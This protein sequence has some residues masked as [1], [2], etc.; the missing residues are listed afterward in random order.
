[1]IFDCPD[2]R[3]QQPGKR[4]ER[5]AKPPNAQ[6]NSGDTGPMRHFKRTEG[7]LQL[8][9]L[10]RFGRDGKI[11]AEDFKCFDD[12]GGTTRFMGGDDGYMN[13]YFDC[14][15][16]T[17]NLSFAGLFKDN[18][19]KRRVYPMRI[20]PNMNEEELAQ[21]WVWA[22]RLIKNKQFVRSWVKYVRELQFETDFKPFQVPKSYGF[23]DDIAENTAEP[24]DIWLR[25]FSEGGHYKIENNGYFVNQ[26]QNDKYEFG[27]SLDDLFINYMSLCEQ[28]NVQF[29]GDKH[30]FNEK[31]KDKLPFINKNPIRC[32]RNGNNYRLRLYYF[33]NLDNSLN[34]FDND[35]DNE[36]D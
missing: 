23:G 10:P 1:V 19:I 5:L 16:C 4:L 22:W 28:N 33:D 20:K 32:S 21:K 18:G 25:S 11:N 6:K 9:E 36:A 14:D 30:S 2:W 31:L 34:I 17:N 12:D 8:N 26:K 27:Y 29:K 13:F 15:L 35:A 24:I 7:Y 3:A